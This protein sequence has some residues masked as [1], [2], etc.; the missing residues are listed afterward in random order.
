MQSNR[1]VQAEGKRMWIHRRERKGK[2]PHDTS[3]FYDW[4]V[5]ARV[6]RYP[7]VFLTTTLIYLLVQ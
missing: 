2:R 7:D 1:M 3:V 5:S 4:P 6:F